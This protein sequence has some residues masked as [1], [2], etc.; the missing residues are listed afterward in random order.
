MTVRRVDV[1]DWVQGWTGKTLPPAAQADLIS[2]TGAPADALIADFGR[3]FAVDLTGY[4]PAMHD[5]GGQAWR[6]GWPFAV[7]PPCGVAVPLSVSLLHAAA[8]AGRWPVRYPDLPPVRELPLLR[9]LS[10][11]N[12]PLMVAGLVGVTLAVLWLVAALF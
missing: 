10:L 9:D 3:R 5:G 6:P 8:L 7:R 11:L 1:L 4:R 12:V 2:A